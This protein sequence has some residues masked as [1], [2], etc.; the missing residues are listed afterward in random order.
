MVNKIDSL[1]YNVIVTTYTYTLL[2][3]IQ[4]LQFC[5]QIKQILVTLPHVEHDVELDT[6][7]VN[8]E[9]RKPLSVYS[10]PVCTTFAIFDE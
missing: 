10:T 6:K 9:E 5:L 8:N 4:L 3:I 2:W 7:L 1:K